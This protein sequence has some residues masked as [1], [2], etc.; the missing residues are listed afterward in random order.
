[1]L[2]K[3]SFFLDASKA[4]AWTKS[5]NEQGYV[6]LGKME[7][8]RFQEMKSA[9]MELI[10]SIPKSDKSNQLLNLINA[11][12]PIKL[13]SNSLIERYFNPI[14]TQ[15]ISDQQATI[16]PVSH[17]LKP[18]GLKSDIWHQD[19]SIVDER[20]AF[21]LNAWISLIPSN[22]FNGCLWVVPGSHHNDNHFRQFG[23]NPVQG[24][25]LRKMNKKIVPIE[26]DAGE[27]VLFHRN[28]LH[29][30]SRNWLPKTRVALESVVISKGAQLYNFHREE[31]MH[32]NKIIGFKVDMEH[33]LRENPK[34]DFY[35]NR[36][37]YELYNDEGFDG[38]TAKLN[39]VLDTIDKK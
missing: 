32:K 37:A 8:N 39:R 28:L 33:F 7:E 12:H 29:G 36:Y 11:S 10:H 1:M 13:A 18:F 24:D 30:S 19:S 27:I 34:A 23:Y 4:V 14:L 16:F 2:I 26:V 15:F 17:I 31:S 21:S 6:V 22:R 25:L 5:L 20:D 35:N 38:I 3:P 9:S